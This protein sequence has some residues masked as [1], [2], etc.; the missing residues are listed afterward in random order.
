MPKFTQSLASL[1]LA[2]CALVTAGAAAAA[3]PEGPV[4]VIIPF[5]PAA[6]T[7]A[8]FRQIA[9]FIEKELRVRLVLENRSGANG[10]IGNEFASRAAPDGYTL[11][12]NSTNL[13]LSPLLQKDPK[14][15][16]ERSFV[17]ISK[18]ATSPLV[19]AASARSP[20]RTPAE[21]VTYARQNPGKLNFGGVGAGSPPDLMAEVVKMR[22]NTEFVTVL[23]RGMGPALV[24]LMG[25]NVDFTFSGLLAVKQ[26]FE[27]GVLRPIAVTGTSRAA[28]LPNVPTFA[29]S[30]IDVSP[31][32]SGTWWGLFAPMGTP[33]PIVRALNEAIG[34]ALADP[35]LVRRLE[36]GGYTPA[37]TTP[38]QFAADLAQESLI[39]RQ[40]V[41]RLAAGLSR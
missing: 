26:H 27:S 9:P 4:K 32:V 41:P 34:R 15:S 16:L 30:G 25:G 1:A 24:D 28:I 23:Y 29:E 2:L 5:A 10:D 18:L 14:Y 38:Q 33:E 35:Q 7:D 31:M 8:M 19:M 39:W 40:M 17:P 6:G 36:D 3:Y 12:V 21:F 13:V 11:V 22:T 20:F 37:R